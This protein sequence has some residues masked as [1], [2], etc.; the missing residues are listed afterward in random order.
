MTCLLRRCGPCLI[1]LA[2]AGPEASKPTESVPP[3]V[4]SGAEGGEHTGDSTPVEIQMIADDDPTLVPMH[5][6][7][8]VYASGT[9]SEDGTTFDGTVEYL[10]SRDDE[11]R[12]D[13]TVGLT[14]LAAPDVCDNCD[15]TF[16]VDA[17]IVEDRGTQFC[18][19]YNSWTLLSDGVYVNQHLGFSDVYPGRNQA[20]YDAV[21]VGVGTDRRE[22]GGGYYPGPYWYLITWQGD[23]SDRG[24]TDLDGLTPSWGYYINEE[25]SALSHYDVC[26]TTTTST[27][28]DFFGGT[29]RSGDVDCEGNNT[30]G[31]SV[32][33]LAGQKVS[34]SVDIPSLDGW[35][36]PMLYINGPDGCTILRAYE[37][38]VCSIAPETSTFRGCPSAQFV[39]DRT[40]TYEMWIYSRELGCLSGPVYYDL[41]VDLE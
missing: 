40:G 7:I 39:A 1:L 38:F 9:I 29:K 37:N 35:T 8:D 32:D 24:W 28:T 4:D 33:V 26:S 10:W 18:Y 13:M 23:Y 14:G 41:Y 6:I 27:A 5:Q 25:G 15:Y 34:I 21:L 17:E 30:D 11:V 31:W 2:C 12:C 22:S 19:P 20:Y 36:Y 16:S 3:A